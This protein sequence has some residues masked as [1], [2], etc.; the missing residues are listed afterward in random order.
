M[1]TENTLKKKKSAL[2]ERERVP[3]GGASRDYSA[4][5]G[6]QFPADCDPP[7]ASLA[8]RKGFRGYLL[9]ARCVVLI[10]VLV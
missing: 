2:A 5:I 3:R 6:L 4:V 1:S 10:Y 9:R 8:A 7:E